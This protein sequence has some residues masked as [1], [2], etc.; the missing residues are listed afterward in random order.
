MLKPRSDI[1]LDARYAGYAYQ[2]DAVEALK[3]LQYGAVFHEQGLGKQRLE[4][5]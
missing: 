4:L 3:N 2:L 1:K 5:I